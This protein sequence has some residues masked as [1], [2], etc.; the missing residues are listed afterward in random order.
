MGRASA[1][2]FSLRLPECQGRPAPRVV[3]TPLCL[4]SAGFLGHLFLFFTLRIAANRISSAFSAGS[5]RW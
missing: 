2:S 5:R 4:G 3:M 1:A